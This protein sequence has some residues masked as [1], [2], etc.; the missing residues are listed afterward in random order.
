MGC[1]QEQRAA[2]QCLI[3]SKPEHTVRISD[4]NIGKHE[5]TVGQFRAF[6]EESGY[7]TDAQKRGKSIVLIDV[8]KNY[9]NQPNEMAESTKQMLNN[10][11]TEITTSLV[12]Q[13]G[14]T[15]GIIGTAISGLLSAATHDDGTPQQKW[16][17]VEK[18]GVDWRHDETGN[19]R[20]TN[21]NDHP[22]MHVSKNDATAYCKWLSSKVE[23]KKF[24]LPTEAEWEYAARGGKHSRQFIYSGSNHI[25]D[26]AWS[27]EN[28][29]LRAF[30]VG[31]LNPN[32][33]G[34]YD[35]SG[36][37]SE[38][39]SD[40]YGP[41]YYYNSPGQDPEGP[42]VYGD[43]LRKEK[44]QKKSNERAMKMYGTDSIRTCDN[45]HF[46]IRGGGAYAKGHNHVSF[47]MNT[48]WHAV[49]RSINPSRT[50]RAFLGFRVVMVDD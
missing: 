18:A 37:V 33:L 29:E 5:V 12:D 15:G 20:R 48:A 13:A 19:L 34:L 46:V 44:V 9:A 30:P 41:F 16:E 45:C 17:W 32:E 50:H 28:S 21:E 2:Y 23:G 22:V 49:D 39:C 4:F 25:N 42:M 10:A 26:V 14:V 7:V 31:R 38:W 40:Y 36:N 11:G 47:R 27:R 1:T 43:L 3:D 35:M 24:R 8:T 6:V